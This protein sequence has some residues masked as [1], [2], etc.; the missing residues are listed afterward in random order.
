ML[1]S[2]VLFVSE[3]LN[4]VLL[5]VCAQRLSHKVRNRILTTVLSAVNIAASFDFSLQVYSKL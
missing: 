3:I 2:D 1:Q 5:Y 4:E